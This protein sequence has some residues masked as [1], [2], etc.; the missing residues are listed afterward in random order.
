[1]PNLMKIAP[2][3]TNEEVIWVKAV[4]GVE[5]GESDNDKDDYNKYNILL[6]DL[7]KVLGWVRHRIDT[8]NRFEYYAKCWEENK[9]GKS[10]LTLEKKLAKELSDIDSK[11]D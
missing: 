10:L 1:M 4:A 5:H 9:W 11:A 6:L 2:S 3:L 8:L 7:T